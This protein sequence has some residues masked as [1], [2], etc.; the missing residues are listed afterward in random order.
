MQST[1]FS[2]H[3]LCKQIWQ[4]KSRPQEHSFFQLSKA[5]ELNKDFLL[6]SKT[7][8]KTYDLETKTKTSRHWSQWLHRC[9]RNLPEMQVAL[10]LA[11]R[12][13]SG[14]AHVKP[15]VSGIHRL[16]Q[17]PLL[18]R[19]ADGFPSQHNNTSDDDRLRRNNIASSY[20]VFSQRDQNI[21]SEI[22]M[23]L[24]IFL[25]KISKFRRIMG[26]VRRETV[27]H[28]FLWLRAWFCRIYLFS[29]VPAVRLGEKFTHPQY[30]RLCTK[31][32]LQ[33]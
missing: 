1:F 10:S 12:E 29:N 27:T 31:H 5:S 8:D 11:S 26:L 28:V 18:R 21:A 17:P 32:G 15:V 23:K 13:K 4:E 9:R 24:M 30:L 33:T 22:D 19:Q 7:D 16:L 14:H 2:A 20:S 25:P 6:K 3:A